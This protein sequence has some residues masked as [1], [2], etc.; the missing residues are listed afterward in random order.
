MIPATKYCNKLTYLQIVKF[1]EIANRP[2]KSFIFGENQSAKTE[3]QTLYKL[4]KT[5][6]Q[7]NND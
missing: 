5:A 4:I 7:V 6:I 2:E 1:V 3:T